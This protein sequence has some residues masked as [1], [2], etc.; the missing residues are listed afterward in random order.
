M[1][2]R[3][4]WFPTGPRGPR[5]PRGPCQCGAVRVGRGVS[6]PELVRR[7]VERGGGAGRQAQQE[8]T[9]TVMVVTKIWYLRSGFC[10]SGELIYG[11]DSLD[12]VNSRFANSRFAV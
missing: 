12:P 3:G 8:T 4:P 10:R 6:V 9:R 11:V 7:F 1:G 2:P 5:G